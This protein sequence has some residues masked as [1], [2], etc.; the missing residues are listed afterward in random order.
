ME[1]GGEAAGQP[2]EG[3]EDRESPQHSG[4]ESDDDSEIEE[5][6][7]L[8]MLRRR[9]DVYTV[10]GSIHTCIMPIYTPTI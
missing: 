6:I 5:L 8:N 4:S 9:Y 3:D 2:M 7:A 1:R 10:Y